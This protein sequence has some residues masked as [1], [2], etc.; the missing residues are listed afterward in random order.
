MIHWV[1]AFSIDFLNCFA[2]LSQLLLTT[3]IRTFWVI[4]RIRC[5][6]FIL[7]MCCLITNLNRFYITFGSFCEGVQAFLGPLHRL[8]LQIFKFLVLLRRHTHRHRAALVQW[9][10]LAMFEQQLLDL[11]LTLSIPGQHCSCYN[12]ICK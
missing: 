10:C 3:F 2:F 12:H 7:H 9:V 6:R 5:H 4:L 11:Q 1:L 8:Q